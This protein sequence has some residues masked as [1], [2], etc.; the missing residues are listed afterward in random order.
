MRLFL[1]NACVR[2]EVCFRQE[3]EEIYEQRRLDEAAANEE[4]AAT[5]IQGGGGEGESGGTQP[6]EQPGA[7][8]PAAE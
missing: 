6:A 2:Y 5:G 7:D 8:P 4:P 1:W 3:A